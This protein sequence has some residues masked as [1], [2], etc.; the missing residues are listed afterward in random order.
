MPTPDWLTQRLTDVPPHNRWLGERERRVLAGL[1]FEPRRTSWRLGRWTAKQ[2][3]AAT[4]EI[5]SPRIE[6]LAALDGAPEAWIDREPARV[7]LS[8]SHRGERA[9]AVVTAEPAILGC[10]LELI[11]P[12]SEAFVRTWLAPAEQRALAAAPEQAPL[13]ANLFWSAKEAAAKL[14]HEGLRLDVRRLVVTA[15]APRDGWAPL[16]VAD[17]GGALLGGWWRADAAYVMTVVCDPPSQRPG[18]EMH[19]DEPLE[20]EALGRSG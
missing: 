14:Q 18:H 2:L 7:S 8:L 13:L 6:V 12:R 16:T 10:D 4:L 3:L 19:I 20:R 9:L 17:E 5:P 1:A 15:Q 11:E